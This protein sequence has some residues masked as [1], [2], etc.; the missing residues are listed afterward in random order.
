MQKETTTKPK[1][2]L[3]FELSRSHLFQLLSAKINVEETVLEEIIPEIPAET[4]NEEEKSDDE[5]AVAEETDDASASEGED[6]SDK[7]DGAS[8]EEA[9]AETEEVEKEYKEVV[10]PHTFTV[11]KIVTRP[12]NARLLNEDQVKEAKKRIKELEQ[13]DKDKQMADEAKN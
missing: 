6:A 9:A 8:T 5:T 10:V 7:T 2:S 1:I 11:D 4:K 12:V 3:A 13:R